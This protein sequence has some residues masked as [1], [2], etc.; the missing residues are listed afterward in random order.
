VLAIAETLKQSILKFP[1]SDA[2]QERFSPCSK[3]TS[4][5]GP[6]GLPFAAHRASILV[7]AARR[8]SGAIRDPGPER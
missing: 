4:V 6:Q 1:V 7:V 5:H 8:K 2:A 3:I